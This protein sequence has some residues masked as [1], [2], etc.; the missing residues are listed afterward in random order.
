MRDFFIG[1]L[2]KV[3]AIFVV[4]L[5]LL[6]IVGAFAAL[7]GAAG[8]DGP[9]GIVGFF[10]ILV[11]GGLYTILMGGLLYL[12]LG[13]YYNTKRQADALDRWLNQPR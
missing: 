7:F 6:V 11:G 2:D 1:A 8:S 4:L 9:S 13:I 12:G 10:A 5:A 3:V